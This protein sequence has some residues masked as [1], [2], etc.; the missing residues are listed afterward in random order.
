MSNLIFESDINRLLKLDGPTGGP[1]SRW[2]RKKE[3]ASSNNVSLN[4]SVNASCNKTPMKMCN[5]SYSSKTPGKTPKTP[6]S[7]TPGRSKTPSKTPVGD[8]FIPNRTSTNFDVANFKVL[9]QTTAAQGSNLSTNQEYMSPS[10]VAFRKTMNENLNGDVLNTKILSYK[11]KPPSAPEGFQNNLKV[12][13]SQNKTP[14]STRK[15]I[16]HIPQVAERILDAPDILDDYYLNLID[17]SCNNHLA[18]SLANNVYLW[19]A[20]SGE[21][22]QLVQL[23]NADEYIASVS[24][25]PEG[26]YLAVGTSNGDVQLWDI[27]QQKRLRNM[28]GHAARVSALSWNSYILSS[29]S[30]SGKIHHHDVRVANHHVGTLENHV[31]EICGL[32]WSLDGKVLA[33]G[34]NDN[35]LNVWSASSSNPLHTFT[36]HQAAVKALAWCP[37][38][39]GL[40]ASG[41][42]TADRHIRFWNVNTGSCLNS[43]DTKSQVCS[44]LW[45]REHKELISAHG[46]AQNQLIIWKYPSMHRVTELLGHTQRI[47]HM[48]MSPDGS[49]VVSAAADE[50]LRLWKC[51]EVPDKVKKSSASAKKLGALSMRQSIR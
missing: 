10:K 12:L 47:L 31:Q 35:I 42:G 2:Q 3:E 38:Q 26:N 7:R 32:K 15:T 25:I 45:S 43:V 11:S 1:S 18:V 24:W 17:W 33:S 48:S 27:E 4:K 29:G 20:T 16:R 37:W 51:F 28:S 36:Q 5:R 30:R 23:D 9:Q 21:I 8:R 39:P 6:S 19:N 13:Y 41:G 22:Q 44:I 40:L 49:T 34:G 46:F 14:G 50:T